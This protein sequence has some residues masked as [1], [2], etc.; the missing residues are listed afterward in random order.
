MHLFKDP[1]MSTKVLYC[2]WEYFINII[3][4]LIGMNVIEGK[5]LL[6]QTLTVSS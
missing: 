2:C 6:F 5:F 3:E 4:L 1:F